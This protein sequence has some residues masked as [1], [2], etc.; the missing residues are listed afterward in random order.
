MMDAGRHPRIQL[1]T[2]TEVVGLEGS[3]GDFAARVRRQP[4]YVD[5]TLCIGCGLCAEACLFFTET[6]EPQYTPIHKV[7][8]LRKVWKQEY[9]FWGKLG[10]A[11]GLSKPLTDQELTDWETLVYDGCTMCGRCSMVCPMGIDIAYV[12]RKVKEGLAAAGYSPP[13]LVAAGGRALEIGSPMG[14]TINTLQA[15]IKV[16]EKETGIEIPLDKEGADYMALF[17]SGMAHTTWPRSRDHGTEP[18]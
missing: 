2:L 12:I 13:D 5:P 18:I 10:R 9:T 4:R 1:H 15:T 11:L 14:V 3:A 17:S 6:R 16:Q 8:P 7:A